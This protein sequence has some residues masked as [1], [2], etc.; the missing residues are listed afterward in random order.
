MYAII[1]SHTPNYQPL[2]D[3]TWPNKEE[4]AERHGYLA[5]CKTEGHDPGLKWN[6]DKLYF[7][8]DCMEINPDV[9]WFWWLGSDTLITNFNIKLES[10]TDDNYHFIIGTDGNDLN[11]DS[12]FF[13]NTP[14]GRRYVDFLIE[15]FPKYADHHFL[16]QQAMIDSY[17]I[18]E[19]KS[20]I[21]V[22]EQHWF[23]SHDCWPNGWQ[24]GYG[25]DLLGG[26]AW[27]EPGDLLVHWPGSSLETRLNRHV[28]YYLPKIIK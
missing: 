20:M 21:K 23:N 14:E 19:W 9:E 16:E 3:W 2:A 7:I 15:E 13:R 26:R 8:R 11:N 22:V 17:K 28:P 24:P 5:Y 12:C 10:I 1:S 6:H 18:P 4:Y 25:Y 27:W